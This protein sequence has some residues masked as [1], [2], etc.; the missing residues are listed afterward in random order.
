MVADGD[1]LIALH[2][3]ASAT[4]ALRLQYSGLSNQLSRKYARTPLSRGVDDSFG[5][6]FY[7]APSKD[8]LHRDRMG[9]YNGRNCTHIRGSV[10]NHERNPDSRQYPEGK[11]GERNDLCGVL[12]CF[13]VVCGAL[14]CS[15]VLCAVLWCSVV[16]CGLCLLTGCPVAC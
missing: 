7:L 10:N 11:R 1:G 9:A 5:E 4:S 8:D 14:L 3:Q 6:L 16:L 12:R 15:V 13:V 2:P